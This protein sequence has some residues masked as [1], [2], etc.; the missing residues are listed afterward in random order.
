[1]QAVRT[2]Y[3]TAPPG[4]TLVSVGSNVFW[5]YRDFVTYDYK[6]ATLTSSPVESER[7][8]LKLMGDNPRGSYLLFTRGQIAA[9][10]STG[11]PSGL[12]AE[13]VSAVEDSGQFQLV[14]ANPDARVYRFLPNATAG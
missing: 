7:A 4:A 2:L 1:V 9:E 11:L 5:R 10:I 3:A 13:L 12:G 6:S 8:V 14:Y